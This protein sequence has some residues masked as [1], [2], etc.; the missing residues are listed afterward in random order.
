MGNFYRIVLVCLAI[1]S[2]SA[3][4]AGSSMRVRDGLHPTNIDD[5]VR[6][7]TTY[8]FRT[9]D[10]CYGKD[11]L[12]GVASAIIIPE[13]DS[14]YRFR[15]TGKAKAFLTQVHFESGTLLASQIDPFGAK[16]VYD[17]NVGGFR[18][19]S[20]NDINESARRSAALKEFNQLIELYRETFPD[21]LNSDNAN[22]NF[23]DQ[24]GTLRTKFGELL[25]QSLD[26]A[27]GG[28]GGGERDSDPSNGIRISNSTVAED[29]TILSV[30]GVLSKDVIAQEAR[31]EILDQLERELDGAGNEE[32]NQALAAFI[33]QERSGGAV[34]RTS[35]ISCGADAPVRRGYQIMGPEGWRTFNQDERLLMAMSTSDKPLISVMQQYSDRILNSK[36][37]STA[38]NL[39]LTEETLRII[40]AERAFDGAVLST[41]SGNESASAVVDEAFIQAAE[42]FK[43]N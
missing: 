31:N 41:L 43:G 19:V 37:G 29:T 23:G 17:E 11:V 28:I 25:Q 22:P 33:S 16:V 10:W 2:V 40:R 42:Q 20:A 27:T 36:A 24:T 6:F 1:L 9:F 5:N 8:Y 13:T 32:Q 18:F 35:A 14:L 39:Q 30:D 4:Q 15:M 38:Q 21:D 26:D 7:R 34:A 3:C 12:N